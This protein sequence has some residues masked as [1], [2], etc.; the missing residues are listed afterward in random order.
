MPPDR[1][2]QH[3]IAAQAKSSTRAMSESISATHLTHERKG[4]GQRVTPRPG[5]VLASPERAAWDPEPDY[6]F[7]WV[8][9]S[10]IVMRV[11]VALMRRARDPAARALWRRRVTD[12]VDFS[13][14]LAGIDGASYVATHPYRQ[15]AAAAFRRFLRPASQLRALKGDRLL[16][17]PR[18]NPDGTPDVQHWSRPQ[19]D[20]PALRALTCLAFLAACTERE[21]PATAAAQ[22][23]LRQDLDF[24]LRHAGAPCI[25][26]WE[27]ATAVGQHYYV[28]LVQAAALRRGANWARCDADAAGAYRAAAAR[29]LAALDRHWSEECGCYLA[30]RRPGRAPAGLD[31][32]VLVAAVD[33]GLAS[34]RH[35]PRD[36][37]MR[38]SLA[39]LEAHFAHALPLNRERPAG[40]GIALGRYPGDAYFG[41][42][43]WFPTTLASACLRYRRGAVASGD[44]VMRTVRRL[45][46][47]NG[48]LSEQVDRETGQH[49]SARN[50]A[51]SHA[52]FIEA[53][54]VRE[55]AIQKAVG[56]RSRAGQGRAG[57]PDRP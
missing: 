8:R 6:F 1:S 45:A 53:A 21:E 33:A 7:H 51:W 42:G 54:L 48:A 49:R 55:A 15:R 32:S 29:L 9:D 16:G 39:A 36:S 17:E 24:T 37:H 11:V 50:L 41:G 30:M 27:E 19:Y 3:W 12:F 52:A 26:P 10:A 34:G 47:P 5:S 2:L 56:S 20:G 40:H 18:F 57:R 23:L 46:G 35:S 28:M 25:G 13:L 31:A 4:F 38:A 44:A 22:S 14:A 43:A